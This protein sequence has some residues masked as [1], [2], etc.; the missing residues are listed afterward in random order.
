MQARR[1]DKVA[2]SG[3]CWGSALGVLYAA[4]FPEKFAAY[5]GSGQ[6]GD[7]PAGEASSYAFVLA[8]APQGTEFRATGPPLCVHPG[9]YRFEIGL[10][11]FL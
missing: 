3:H 5:V 11:P 6:I 7:W 4:R 2:I 1:K 8:E 10:D 9:A